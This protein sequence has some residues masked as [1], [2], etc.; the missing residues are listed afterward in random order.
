MTLQLHVDGARWRAHLRA[1]GELEPEV[2][3]VIKGNGYGFGFE[4]LLAEPGPNH[5]GDV[6]IGT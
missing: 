1:V 4:R 2:I 3:P 5:W 6:A